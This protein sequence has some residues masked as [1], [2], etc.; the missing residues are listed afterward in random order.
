VRSVSI[1]KGGIGENKSSAAKS[2]ASSMAQQ[3]HENI[4]K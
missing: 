4:N 1:R 2:A 3:R